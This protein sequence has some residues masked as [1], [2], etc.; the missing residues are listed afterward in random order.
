MIKTISNTS[1]NIEKSSELNST[2]PYPIDQIKWEF[3]EKILRILDSITLNE[4]S[5]LCS[6]FTDLLIQTWF[7][8]SHDLILQDPLPQGEKILYTIELS[9]E[10]K[11]KISQV[12]LYIKL[13]EILEW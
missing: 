13:R 8:F 1:D 10:W 2:I 11:D 4:E 12:F 6:N 9:A 7:D 3:K 5:H